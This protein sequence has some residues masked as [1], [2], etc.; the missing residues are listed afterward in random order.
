MEP[1]RE[2]SE[3]A[4]NG[5][6]ASHQSAGTAAISKRSRIGTSIVS[7]PA[8]AKAYV[9]TVEPAPRPSVRGEAS[10]RC[11]T[12]TER[13]VRPTGTVMEGPPASNRT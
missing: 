5:T 13:A 8:S 12:M 11:A 3:R 9:A 4:R 10:K 2:A 7:R 6:S 1:L